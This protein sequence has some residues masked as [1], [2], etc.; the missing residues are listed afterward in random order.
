MRR[1]SSRWIDRCVVVVEWNF[2][3]NELRDGSFDKMVV[4]VSNGYGSDPS[5]LSRMQFGYDCQ[6]PMLTVDVGIRISYVYEAPDSW[7]FVR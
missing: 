7:Q 5:I 3:W 1:S 6:W 2:Y 4:G